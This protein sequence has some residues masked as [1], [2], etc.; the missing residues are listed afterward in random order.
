VETSGLEPPAPCLQSSAGWK[1]TG[2]RS[3]TSIRTFSDDRVSALSR[4]PLGSP[5]LPDQRVPNGIASQPGCLTASVG[6]VGCRLI[7]RERGLPVDRLS[8]SVERRKEADPGTR[9]SRR[10]EEEKRWN[11]PSPQALEH[12]RS[13]TGRQIAGRVEQA[14]PS[15]QASAPS[16]HR[17][18]LDPIQQRRGQDLL[19][20]E[21]RTQALGNREYPPRIAPLTVDT[22]PRHTCHGGGE[23]SGPASSIGR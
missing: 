15:P 7:H 18:R 1:L 4:C 13:S 20:G 10:Q 11:P 9:R 12:H 6:L 3:L 14:S 16:Q 2:R 22:W 5:P 21:R 8:R 23:P 17:R 19:Y